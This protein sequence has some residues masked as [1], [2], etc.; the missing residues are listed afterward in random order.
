MASVKLWVIEGLINLQLSKE[1]LGCLDIVHWVLHRLWS[2]SNRAKSNHVEGS[3]EGPAFRKIILD[4]DISRSNGLASLPH[5]A[6]YLLNDSLV[7]KVVQSLLVRV[8]ELEFV[9]VG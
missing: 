1:N 7:D 2:R 6:D 9:V 4:S 3:A 5:G 8:L